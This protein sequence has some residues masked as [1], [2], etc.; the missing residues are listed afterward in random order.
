MWEAGS[1][2]TRELAQACTEGGVA[3]WQVEAASDLRPEWFTPYATVGLTA[4][5]STT[6]AAIQDVR[7]RLEAF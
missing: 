7:R 5:T 1:P 2:T 6:D 4:G 3:C